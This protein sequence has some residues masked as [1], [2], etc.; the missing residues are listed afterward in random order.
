MLIKIHGR[1]YVLTNIHN[2]LSY[3]SVDPRKIKDII[4][5]ELRIDYNV[6]EVEFRINDKNIMINAFLK[7]NNNDLI[8]LGF[9][10]F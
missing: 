8:S 7:E 6:G 4:M 1:Q 3:I 2:Y 10:C 5:N 9:E